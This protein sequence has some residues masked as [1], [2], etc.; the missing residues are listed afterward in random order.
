[1]PRNTDPVTFRIEPEVLEELRLLADKTDTTVS[2]I[3]RRGLR[4]VMAELRE[5]A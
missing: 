3:I 2:Q 1:M 5:A 4:K